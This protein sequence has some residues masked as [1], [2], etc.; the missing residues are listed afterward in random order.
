MGTIGSPI[1]FSE[2]PGVG[3]LKV[4]DGM[5]ATTLTLGGTG[6]MNGNV[7]VT[8]NGTLTGAA[9]LIDGGNL[10]LDLGSSTLGLG[11]FQENS[12]GTLTLQASGPGVSSTLSLVG[13]AQ[14]SG[15]LSIGF[16]GGYTP[17]TGDSFS[18]LTAG[19]ITGHFDT[20]PA[21]MTV[22]YSPTGVTLTQN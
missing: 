4:G 22:G 9:Q 20:T 14:L 8:N 5:T 1:G 18:V 17:R 21:N 19:S 16:V 10:I 6:L 13:Q 3:K 11:S 2:N 15:I 12:T 7:E